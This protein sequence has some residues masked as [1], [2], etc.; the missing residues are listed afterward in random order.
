MLRM[1]N[2]A[3]ST[4]AQAVKCGT[5]NATFRF[6]SPL[7]PSAAA[8]NAAGPA[9]ATPAAAITCRLG[10]HGSDA[11]LSPSAPG[12]ASL[13]SV[14][15]GLHCNGTGSS[16][17]ADS[18]DNN[19]DGG[20][21]GVD[22]A[23]VAATVVVITLEVGSALL[24][25][26]QLSGSGVAFNVIVSGGGA[27]DGNRSSD[28]NGTISASGATTAAAHWGLAFRGVPSLE[29]V[30]SSVVGVPLSS[31]APLV[32]CW[33]V[34]GG[35]TSAA[36]FGAVA[37]T[38]VVTAALDGFSC[39]GVAGASS[40]ACVLLEFQGSSPL[41]PLA[42]TMERCTFVNNAV[43]YS[44]AGAAVFTVD[45]PVIDGSSSSSN[46][47]SG[48]AALQI[49]ISNS[50][51]SGNSGGS[52]PAVHASV[53]VS[54]LEVLQ[55]DISDNLGGFRSACLLA[56]LPAGG[57]VHVAGRL[58]SLAVGGGTS[59]SGNAAAL[60]GAIH[61]ESGIDVMTLTNKSSMSGNSARTFGGAVHT[62]G[63]LQA[64]TVG[65]GSSISGNSASFGGLLHV[66]TRAQSIS[67][68]GGSSVSGNVAKS[69]SGGVAYVAGRV[70]EF[71]IVGSSV[72]G[73]SAGIF[74]GVLS[75]DDAVE[76]IWVSGGS[77]VRGNK[78]L[79]SGGAF[80]GGKTVA[81]VRVTDNAGVTGNT[82]GK[83]GGALY[84]E[85]NMGNLTVQDAGS[86]SGN[87]AVKSG[88][89]FH[90]EKLV[91][92]VVLRGGAARV[93][94]NSANDGGAMYVQG[95][96]VD[97][98]LLDG[99]SMGGNVALQGSGG[100]MYA[101]GVG[102]VQV[103]DNS[104]LFSN[105]AQQGGALYTTGAVG[106]MSADS[107]AS[108]SG[109][110]AGRN[111]GFAMG[112]VDRAAFAACSIVG[113]VASNA[114]G[115]MA[116]TASSNQT[117]LSF[118]AVNASGNIAMRD[119]GGV[120]R[121]VVSTSRASPET[122]RISLAVG[123]GSRITGNGAYQDGGVFSIDPDGPRV[124]RPYELE[125][126][127]Q[128]SD[129]SA[130]YAG[131]GGAVRIRTTAALPYSTKVQL[132][133]CRLSANVA[134]SD[135]VL[136]NST[137]SGGHGG[138]V[139]ITPLALSQVDTARER[140]KALAS[141]NYEGL[142]PLD[143]G[144]SGRRLLAAAVVGTPPPCSVQLENV[145]FLKNSC[146][147]NG[148]ALATSSCL[149]TMD[150]CAFVK[151][152][153]GVNG[154]AVAGLLEQGS[155]LGVFSNGLSS[156][157]GGDSEGE[158][159]WFSVM[160]ST[161]D[162][163][164]AAASGG[165]LYAEPVQNLGIEVTSSIFR[166]NVAHLGG[167]LGLI[168][169]AATS[170]TEAAT[171]PTIRPF[172]VESSTFRLNR[173]AMGGAM[174]ASGG[175]TLRLLTGVVVSYNSASVSGGGVAADGCDEL[176]L[177]GAT[178][179]NN[180]AADQGG[181]AFLR[182]C[183]LVQL[184]HSEVAFNQASTGGGLSVAGT[185]DRATVGLLRNTSFSGN[186]AVA[187]DFRYGRY[188]GHG[189]AVF[190]Q[191]ATALLLHENGSFAGDNRARAGPAVAAAQ[192]CVR[193]DSNLGGANTTVFNTA[194]QLLSEYDEGGDAKALLLFSGTASNVS[195]R[196]ASPFGTTLSK[197][198][199]PAE[200]RPPAD[201]DLGVTSS[202][203]VHGTSSWPFMTVVGW[204]GRY[205]LNFTAQ[206]THVQEDN[207][208]ISPLGLPAFIARC[209]PGEVLDLSP[210]K[211]PGASPAWMGC[212][213][214]EAG[215]FSV[216]LDDRADVQTLSAAIDA[217]GAPAT[218][219]THYLEAYVTSDGDLLLAHEP[220]DGH[221]NDDDDVGG[222]VMALAGS[223]ADDLQAKDWRAL[224]DSSA[225]ATDPRSGALALSCPQLWRN[226]LLSIPSFLGSVILVL[227]TLYANLRENY[228]A[229]GEAGGEEGGKGGAAD[230]DQAS[231]A[232][233]LKV[234]IIHAQYYIII[235][236][237]PIPYPD[238]MV[239]MVAALSAVTGA[240][241]AVA[242]S[243]SC[244]FQHHG[245]GGQAR[246]QLLGA[247]VVPFIVVA[248]S[249]VLWGLSCC[250]NLTAGR[251]SQAIKHSQPYRVLAQVDATLGLR[252]QLWITLVIAVFILYPGWAQA[253]L[254]VFA[255]YHIDDG[256]TGPFPD[257]HQA[258]WR[259]G[260]WVRDM[261][262][263][264]Y[265]GTHLRLYV[266]IG[267][268]AVICL[269]LGPPLA[270]FML[271]WR[272]RRFLETQR[273]KQKPQF[274]W[275]ES[276]LMLQELALVAVE[277]FG[278]GLEVVSHQILV[279]LAAFIAISALNMTCS[280][281]KYRAITLLEFLSMAVLSLTVS[282]SLFFVVDGGMAT[283]D[284]NAVGAI[285]LALNAAL[286]AA[287]L[288]VA[289]RHSWGRVRTRL[290]PLLSKGATRAR[291]HSR[292]NK[293]PPPQCR[294][295]EGLGGTLST[296]AA[297]AAAAAAVAAAQPSGPSVQA[298]ANP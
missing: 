103:T 182:G 38:G 94:N 60:G 112:R 198:G 86:I 118:A 68:G 83:R 87:S 59:I 129:I 12:G 245:S 113:N 26:L 65:G 128:D 164:A 155:A 56:C 219:F 211:R 24:P 183:A 240:E 195:V 9:S 283:R 136:R 237:L 173:A 186:A 207:L 51:L 292:P 11:A 221:N 256:V 233:F 157:A 174:H 165:G 217:E 239:R 247:L 188:A 99:G 116:L 206:S 48:S 58:A 175:V 17:A 52:G 55:S 171:D 31:A 204:P 212:K 262:Q 264:C 146:A 43:G 20:G 269:C 248:T 284:A 290:E 291:T 21:G 44:G 140:N 34:G 47:S 197:V 224:L 229:E 145:V 216:W 91:L 227:Y 281:I 288:A 23:T 2:L 272:H 260:Y 166:N 282:L 276:V 194:G 93:W 268:V 222:L 75:S 241:S 278:R 71:A 159:L 192:A 114:G 187:S 213:R 139:L 141:A 231:P 153:A 152:A 108:I 18:T 277:V 243:Y 92:S 88:G 14:R 158:P 223:P 138:A 36:V 70:T 169:V 251:V 199:F 236:R 104:R 144:G 64:L 77:S 101:D 35:G 193:A 106:Y 135:N 161:F 266:P 279:M 7:L 85:G 73:N 286:L 53:P 160:N 122:I 127:F 67:I 117:S 57:A 218:N 28:G 226:A 33:W 252:M 80:Y 100:A 289:L 230:G 261:A 19:S 66:A 95:R 202:A 215:R 3:E 29:L 39:A 119:S 105:S 151:N 132:R 149:V 225:T 154:G 181:G 274:F 6:A 110:T 201:L 178:L 271:L 294:A 133:N 205:L 8:P 235:L 130:N 97:V 267:I 131:A 79:D 244:F 250:G 102:T 196:L 98:V 200:E 273:V 143:G 1:R 32:A 238:L 45:A 147:G 220:T 287:F 25:S 170:A 125:A 89:A 121:L 191:G 84:V 61:A 255:C 22:A 63:G 82:A 210:T 30:D 209:Q 120:L 115:V 150:S 254:S 126:L 42:V 265:S 107:G 285:I 242:F 263:E 172:T 234:A 176:L 185:A 76:G 4:S 49:R 297:V 177:D 179:A 40:W 54:V 257:R 163:N 124:D 246:V 74:G 46:D 190:V 142:Q 214:C 137:A 111:G 162:S 258:A 78:A 16:G 5:D 259:H 148:G 203:A 275:W 50:S 10:L 228:T 134:G 270:S 27:G 69:G 208:T 72:V 13:L 96:A 123:D 298:V 37:A 15:A 249:V 168:T 232:D 295:N 293:S 280:P 184:Q 90:F 296:P 156:S 81:W 167:G 180:T 189:G 109:N 253:A 41:L 62:F